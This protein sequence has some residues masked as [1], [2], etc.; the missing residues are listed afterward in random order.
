MA[1]SENTT[2]EVIADKNGKITTV[3]KGRKKRDRGPEID[4]KKAK[5]MKSVPSAVKAEA[6]AEE[7]EPEFF[8]RPL[9]FEPDAEW[10][11]A[12]LNRRSLRILR[13]MHAMEAEDARALVEGMER[14]SDTDSDTYNS[15]L[16][17]AFDKWSHVAGI[18]RGDASVEV[19][20]DIIGLGRRKQQALT[21]LANDDKAQE[22]IAEHVNARR[23]ADEG[24]VDGDEVR[25]AVELLRD[26]ASDPDRAVQARAYAFIAKRRDIDEQIAE[27]AAWKAELETPLRDLNTGQT[28]GA[29]SYDIAPE[30]GASVKFVPKSKYDDDGIIEALD[31]DQTKAATKT[32]VDPRLARELLGKDAVEQYRHYDSTSVTIR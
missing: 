3:H 30:D 27:L 11:S 20:P 13:N 14:R 22:V 6:E 2:P 19:D 28:S 8:D 10:G 17:T 5:A 9:R 31:E 7:K 4:G 25:A 16:R 12:H 23:K 26:S 21:L 29:Y 15:A 32:F 1:K 18:R 24:L